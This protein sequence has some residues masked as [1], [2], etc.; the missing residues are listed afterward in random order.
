M[1]SKIILHV[2]VENDSIENR[3]YRNE[4]R[5]FLARQTVCLYHRE[6]NW[7]F[8]S[9]FLVLIR[10]EWS[11]WLPSATIRTNRNIMFRT[12]WECITSIFAR[13]SYSRGSNSF[14]RWS[15]KI[16]ENK[17]F[18]LQLTLNFFERSQIVF[19]RWSDFKFSN[20]ISEG[21]FFSQFHIRAL[22]IVWV[23]FLLS[24]LVEF[25][26]W[27]TEDVRR[28]TLWTKTKKVQFV[29]MTMYIYIFLSTNS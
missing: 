7:S 13:S 5:V 10:K 26:I 1:F 29:V 23:S 3:V 19:G 21:S 25:Y 6:N 22:K 28:T 17:D 18:N 27:P 20:S 8:L 9:I 11:L 2:S 4:P 12:R 15:K 16:V 14:L 24:S